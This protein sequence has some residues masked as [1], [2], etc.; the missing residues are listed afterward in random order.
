LRR[1]GVG[2]KKTTTKKAWASPVQLKI[3]QKYVELQ[4]EKALYCTACQQH[5]SDHWCKTK[6]QAVL[7]TQDIYPGSRIHDLE[8]DFIH[9]GS[10]PGSQIRIRLKE[11]K[12][13]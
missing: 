11:F 8:F 7:R 4:D 9:P 13:F 12:Y 6:I 2:A 1:D 5:T 10:D 3:S